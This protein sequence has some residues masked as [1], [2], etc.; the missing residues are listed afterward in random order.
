MKRATDRGMRR[1]RAATLLAVGAIIGMV[2]VA[3]PAGAHVG[4][5]VN[6]LWGHLKPKAD[7]RYANVV[8]GTDKAKD[9]DMLD[10]QNGT[11]Y[12]PAA[13]EGWHVVGAAG[14]PAFENSWVNYG[15]GFSSAAFYKDPYGVVHLKGVVQLG[16]IGTTIFS[17]P[18]GYLPSEDLIISTR[19]NNASGEVRI[20]VGCFFFCDDEVVAQAGSNTWF[21]LD[22]ISFRAG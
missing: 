9:A 11:Y 18:S 7:A 14:E 22:G 17:L 15:G 12:A 19:S 4:G 8:A 20:L 10:G 5:T 16:T 1:W 2:M 3:T 6:H 13:V 21:S